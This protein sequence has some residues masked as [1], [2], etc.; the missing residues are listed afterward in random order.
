MRD[1]V[2][3]RKNSRYGRQP[4]FLELRKSQNRRRGHLFPSLVHRP[5][6]RGHNWPTRWV[7]SSH[8]MRRIHCRIHFFSTKGSH[9]A[10][11]LHNWRQNY[12]AGNQGNHPR[13]D[14]H[15]EALLHKATQ[16]WHTRRNQ[17]WKGDSTVAP[18]SLTMALH[19]EATWGLDQQP[20]STRIQSM[21]LA[22][23]KWE[24]GSVML[25]EH[26]ERSTLQPARESSFFSRSLKH[27]LLQNLIYFFSQRNI[28]RVPIL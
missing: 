25:Q 11:L 3:E 21:L 7:R 6:W 12:P 16:G 13:E 23:K 19:Q 1:W 28:E 22:T 20:L 14:A 5:H 8:H 4:L 15:P 10:V 24:K 27:F 9:A 17:L 26:N 18:S 2:C